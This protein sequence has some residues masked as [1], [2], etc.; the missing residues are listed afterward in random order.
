MRVRANLK[1]WVK[2]M[3][4]SALGGSEEVENIVTSASAG[5]VGNHVVPK[6]RDRS[7]ERKYNKDYWLSKGLEAY[8]RKKAMWRENWLR[9][10]NEPSYRAR[11]KV[12]RKRY[13]RKHR[14]AKYKLSSSDYD[15]LLKKQ[16]GVCAICKQPPT[17]GKNLPVDHCHKSKKVRGLLCLKCNICISQGEK[18][19]SWF[20]TAMNY[21]TSHRP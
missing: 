12:L 7:R 1:R 13:K 18:D 3:V 5:A 10:R 11:K 6:K 14:L 4:C 16:G 2:L 21:L 15:G 8:E 19:F 9:H 17:E 20:S